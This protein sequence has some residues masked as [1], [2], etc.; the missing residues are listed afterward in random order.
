MK[1]TESDVEYVPG[2]ANLQVAPEERKQLAAELSPVLDFVQQLNKLDVG[3]ID[4]TPQIVTSTRRADRDDR[5]IPRT[6]SS[7]A[8]KSVKLFRVPKVITER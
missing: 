3:G 1:I 6:G 7:E 4:P 5:V 2:L 8:G